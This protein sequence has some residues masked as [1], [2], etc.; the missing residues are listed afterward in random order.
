MLL[1]VNKMKK[2][3]DKFHPMRNMGL[4]EVTPNERIGRGR[5]GKQLVEEL[6]SKKLQ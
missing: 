4:I 1:C 5:H 2:E 6:W 3:M